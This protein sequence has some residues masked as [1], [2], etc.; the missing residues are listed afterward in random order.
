MNSDALSA[1]QELAGAI[2][3]P[4]ERIV[5]VGVA[6]VEIADP[7]REQ[8]LLECGAEAVV[9][10]I[11]WIVRFGRQTRRHLDAILRNVGSHSYLATANPTPP[12]HRQTGS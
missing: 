2:Q 7:G 9:G 10:W 11:H 4:A 12:P 6:L 5:D 1:Y 8:A 3:Q